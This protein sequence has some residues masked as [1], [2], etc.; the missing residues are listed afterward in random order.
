MFYFVSKDKPIFSILFFRFCILLF[1]SQNILGNKSITTN[2]IQN[3][4]FQIFNDFQVK[5]RSYANVAARDLNNKPPLPN[6]HLQVSTSKPFLDTP[7][8]SKLL[9]QQLRG[10]NYP[11]AEVSPSGTLKKGVTP[12]GTPKK[13]VT[14]VATP[15]SGVSPMVTPKRGVSPAVTPKPGVSPSVTPKKGVTPAVT[16]NLV[17]T[18]SVTPNSGS[19]NSG[20]S[21]AVSITLLH[22]SA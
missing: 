19:P 13:G 6:Q 4:I 17:V 16:P 5:K 10:T 7:D 21:P 20:V 12:S 18:P 22:T 14:P 1:P 2:P 9:Q 11:K 3:L 8:H 15:R